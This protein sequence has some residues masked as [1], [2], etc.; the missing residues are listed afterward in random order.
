[1]AGHAGNESLLWSIPI[2]PDKRFQI[3]IF[4]IFSETSPGD[5]PLELNYSG[6]FK[7]GEVNRRN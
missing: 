6:Y 5:Y 3:L 4:E 1:M 2:S 7:H